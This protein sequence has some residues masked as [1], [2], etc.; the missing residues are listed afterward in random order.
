MKTWTF[1]NGRSVNRMGFG[2]MRLSGQPGYWGPYADK[3]G[4]ELLLRRGLELGLNFIDTSISYGNGHSEMLLAELLHPYPSGLMIATK[5]GLVKLG[6][7]QYRHDGTPANLRGSC[8]ASLKYLKLE[9][10]ELYQLHRID[11]EV[12]LE[13]SLGALA[14]L[15]REGKI[16]RIGLSGVTVAEIK[17]AQAV[18]EIAS[19]QNRYNLNARDDE[20]V[21]YCADQNIAYIC[22]GPL[23][24]SGYGTDARLVEKGSPAEKLAQTLGVTPG[25][26]ALAWLLAKGPHMIPI[27]GTTSVKHLEENMAAGIIELAPEQIAGLDSA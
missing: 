6:P 25:Q 1:S 17:R 14:D 5:G 12:P 15:K 4:A 2:A 7:A 8:E 3:P 18:T 20:V 19:V 11:P 10:I 27:P 24:A 13:E 22:Y 26:I 21:K 9:T 23:D 16:E